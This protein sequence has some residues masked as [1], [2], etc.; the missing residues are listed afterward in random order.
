MYSSVPLNALIFLCNPHHHPSR[1]F[2]HLPKVKFYSY[3]PLSIS[4]PPAP[5]HHHSTLCLCEFDSSR[6]LI[7]V[8]SSNIVLCIM[9]M[10]IF[11]CIMQYISF[12]PGSF[13][14]AE[15]LP[16]S[17]MLYHVS[18]LNGNEQRKRNV[19]RGWW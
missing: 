13:H 9:C 2:F 15:C 3:K 8:E 1:E 4:L 11:L 6:H 16:G 19:R 18:F 10:C 14:L 5:G 12:V 7:E 17:C